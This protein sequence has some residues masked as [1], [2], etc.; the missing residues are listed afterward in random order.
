MK[1]TTPLLP[2]YRSVDC[3]AHHIVSAVKLEYHSRSVSER[4]AGAV[5]SV[6]FGVHSVDPTYG[7]IDVATRQHEE[8]FVPYM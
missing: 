7:T 4:I 5:G 3:V 1:V 6:L 2:A 8:A